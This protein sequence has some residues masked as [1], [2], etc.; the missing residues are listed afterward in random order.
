MYIGT[1][2]AVLAATVAVTKLARMADR[3]RV[4]TRMTVRCGRGGKT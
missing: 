4:T 3:G 1:G 2:V